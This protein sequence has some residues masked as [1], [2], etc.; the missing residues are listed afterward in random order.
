[1]A[2][3]AVRFPLPTPART[4]TQD[5]DAFDD[6]VERAFTG[7]RRALG[8]VAI[9][10]GATLLDVARFELGDLEHRAG[11]VLQEFFVAAVEGRLRFVPGTERAD[12]ALVRIVR[13]MAAKHRTPSICIQ[14]ATITS[15]EP[16]GFAD[17]SRSRHSR[18]RAPTTPGD[19]H[20]LAPARLRRER[21]GRR[22]DG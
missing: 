17:S 18:P 3:R 12:A 22:N 19:G 13:E 14:N 1:M 6:L 8:A 16:V 5:E 7:D 21:R 4:D 10:T 11:N 15:Q 9:A 20:R 2:I